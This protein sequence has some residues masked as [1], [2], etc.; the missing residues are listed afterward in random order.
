[1]HEGALEPHKKPEKIE[2][3]LD[4]TRHAIS[5]DLRAIS[6]KLSP[7]H[8]KDQAKEA[9]VEAKDAASEKIHELKD[10][11]KEKLAEAKDAAVTTI[12]ETADEAWQEARKVS[13][14]GAQFVRDNAIPLAMVGIG[15]AWLVQANRKGRRDEWRPPSRGARQGVR[16]VREE[17]RPSG[18]GDGKLQDKLSKATR[19]AADGAA[20]MGHRAEE[21]VNRATGAVSEVGQHARDVA[22]REIERVREFSSGL[23]HENPLAL[24]AAALAAGV[25]L[26][27]LM[28]ATDR[29][30]ELIGAQRDHL[31]ED[32]KST[33]GNF[34]RAAKDAVRGVGEML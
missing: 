26:G 13:G 22:G 31:L 33:A 3:E 8:L 21:V 17:G 25:A 9:L 4:E 28:P 29:E 24:G 15:V 30:N 10:S 19:R 16:T 34:G 12:T 18:N 5:Q 1:M 32:A 7:E 20:E 14:I 6:E 27:M 11:A 23:A 2:V